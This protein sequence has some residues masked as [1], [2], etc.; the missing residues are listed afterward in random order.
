M[1]DAWQT[2]PVEFK[3]GLVSNLSPLQQ[4]ANLPGSATVLQNSLNLL[5]RVVT[6]VY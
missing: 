2:Y 4:G 5:L 6:D 1:A 3:G